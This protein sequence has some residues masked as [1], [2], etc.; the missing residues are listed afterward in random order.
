MI[1]YVDLAKSKLQEK[2]R[3]IKDSGVTKKCPWGKT[4]KLNNEYFYRDCALNMKQ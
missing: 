4:V 2:A 1:S 3:S